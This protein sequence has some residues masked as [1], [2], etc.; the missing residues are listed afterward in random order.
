MSLPN[1]GMG[2]TN[3]VFPVRVLE[4]DRLKLVPVLVRAYLILH[5]FFLDNLKT[6]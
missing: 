1:G 6:Y 5:K 3:F 4:S 2:G